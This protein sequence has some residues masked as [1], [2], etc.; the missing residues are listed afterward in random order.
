MQVAAAWCGDTQTKDWQR[1]GGSRCQ[2]SAGGAPSVKKW[3]KYGRMHGS[4]AR[5][6]LFTM[7][8]LNHNTLHCSTQ[9]A[10]TRAPPPATADRPPPPACHSAAG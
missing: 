10:S 6:K 9:P 1:G 5:G 2:S 3:C 8:T 4:I 7:Q